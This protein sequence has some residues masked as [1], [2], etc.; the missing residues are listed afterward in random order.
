[1]NIM[2]ALK[3]KRSLLL[4]CYRELVKNVAVM[5]R[6]VDM[7]LMKRVLVSGTCREAEK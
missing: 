2:L 7:S 5:R 4:L 1:M 3:Y 6:I